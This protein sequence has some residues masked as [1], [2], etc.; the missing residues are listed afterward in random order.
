MFCTFIIM[1]SDSDTPRSAMKGKL[2]FFL[3]S[4]PRPRHRRPNSV[5]AQAAITTTYCPGRHFI[6]VLY[7]P[8]FFD[9]WSAQN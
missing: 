3:C 4:S 2:S 5:Q 6:L 8:V 7:L 9:I 1:K